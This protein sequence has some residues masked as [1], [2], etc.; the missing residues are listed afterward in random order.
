MQSV[1]RS[2]DELRF[3]DN[4]DVRKVRNRERERGRKKGIRIGDWKEGRKRGKKGDESLI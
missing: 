2:K 3:N 4:R 1:D